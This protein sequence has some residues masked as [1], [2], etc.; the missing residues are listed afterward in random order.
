M[1]HLAF[2]GRLSQD[3][4]VLTQRQRQVFLAVVRRHD[5]TA[6]P[7]SSEALVSSAAVHGSAP[8]VRAVLAELEA[9]GLVTRTHAASGR[10]PTAAG[11]AYYVRQALMPAPL[12]SD[13][14]RE[15]D[16]RLERSTR[17]VEELLHEAAR[18]LSGLSLQL[19]LAVSSPLED[20]R[21]RA[22][23]LAPLAPERAL[24][25]LTLDGGAVRTLKLELDS[26]LEPG[27]LA[28]V[29]RVLRERLTGL[30][31][32]EVRDRLLADPELVRD[33]VV[34][35]VAAAFAA[36]WVGGSDESSTLFSAGA[37]RIAALP[38]FAAPEQLGSLLQAIED[39]PPLDRLLV[40][41]TEGVAEVRLA[42]DE[43]GALALCSLVRFPLPG[44]HRMAVGVLGPLR[45]DYARALAVVD[46]VGSRLAARL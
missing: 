8:A 40:D 13:V 2:P 29:E 26:P 16:E 3:D 15:I 37:G 32:R 1:S 4:P 31:L 43:S 44:P 36:A 21:L 25:V 5:H 12:P 6:R 10:V 42:L 14:L 24:L 30:H 39:G 22:I 23:E 11:Y 38:E 45:M 27:A 33:T 41:G 46:A 17:A 9:S 28:E 35:A 19:G 18:I 34:H 7:V 20:E